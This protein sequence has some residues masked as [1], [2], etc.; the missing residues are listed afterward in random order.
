MMF[1]VGD[2]VYDRDD[3]IRASLYYIVG[4]L[5]MIAT[6]GSIR[7]GDKHCIG[8]GSIIS[9]FDPNINYYVVRTV[10]TIDGEYYCIPIEY[11]NTSQDKILGMEKNIG[12]IGHAPS[13]PVEMSIVQAKV[14]CPSWLCY[15]I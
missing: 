6:L 10:V 12:Q 9:K 3:N 8:T 1:K 15:K 2:I 14:H 11:S 13:I 4:T 7:P 5:H